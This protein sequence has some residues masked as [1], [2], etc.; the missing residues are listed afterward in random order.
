MNLAV[1]PARGGSKRIPKKNIQLFNGKPMIVW[2]INKAKDSKLF[3]R[4]IV[5]T[6]DPEISRIAQL[7][8][9]YTPFTRPQNLSDDNTPTVP[10]ISH[11]IEMLSIDGLNFEYTCCIYP[12]SPTMQISDLKNAFK[13][14]L[15]SNASYVYP[16]TE[17]SH[18]IQRAMYRESN[19]KMHFIQPEHELTR[20]QDLQRTYHDAGM[21]YWGKT[22]SWLDKLP[23]HTAGVS[24]KLPHW[25]V[26]DIDNQEDWHRA[27]ILCKAMTDYFL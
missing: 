26:V 1:I 15:T 13:L 25:R 17:Y 5:S 27:E 2:A 9:A 12:C 24:I 18:P 4:I 7:E 21:F 11:A 22:K 3:D 16:T 14:L 10:V 20:T 6:D 8:G 23:M 19:G